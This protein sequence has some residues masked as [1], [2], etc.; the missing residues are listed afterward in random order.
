[1]KEGE[2]GGITGDETKPRT[3]LSPDAWQES[4]FSRYLRGLFVTVAALAF[5]AGTTTTNDVAGS[6]VVPIVATVAIGRSTKVA[7][8][9]SAVVGGETT[10][11]VGLVEGTDG[12]G[13]VVQFGVHGDGHFTESNDKTENGNGRDQHE[14]GRNDETSFV[15]PQGI[16]AIHVRVP[17]VREE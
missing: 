13:D 8:E 17:F 6:V 5:T 11:G 14:F 1:V 7:L 3:W 16:Q 12:V 9:L 15:I 10:V 4:V 2:I